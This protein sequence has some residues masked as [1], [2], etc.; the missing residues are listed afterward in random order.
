ML[1]DRYVVGKILRQN[2]EGFEYLGYDTVMAS[3]VTVREYLP[4]NLA[5]RGED[6]LSVSVIDGCEI[7]FGEYKAEFL[8][9][10]RSVARMRELN[11]LLPIYDI[12]EENGAAYTISEWVESITLREFITRSGGSIEWS[13]ARPLF[14]PVLSAMSAMHSGGVQHLGLSPD[15]LVIVREG[16]MKLTGF[17]IRAVRQA[18]TDLAPELYS[19]CAAIEQY[20]MDYET[21]ES[22][23]VYGFTACLFYAPV[24]YTHLQLF[25]FILAIICSLVK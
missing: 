4:P 2:G 23:D 5:S 14:M 3:T 24:S 15:N 16:K 8:S 6:G 10:Y 20:V 12:F 19:G 1:Q 9:Y 18:D 11:V 7:S 13:V 25:T 17:C 21:T 22:T